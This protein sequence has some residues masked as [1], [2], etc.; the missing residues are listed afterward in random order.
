MAESISTFATFTYL[1]SMF[2]INIAF[3]VHWYSLRSEL[4]GYWKSSGLIVAI[5]FGLQ[6]PTFT[7]PLAEPLTLIMFT[8]VFGCFKL[9][10]TSG[11]GLHYVSLIHGAAVC[12]KSLDANL[13][14]QIS[15]LFILEKK[16]WLAV[17]S[18]SVL[19]LVVF[20]FGLFWV[21]GATTSKALLELGDTEAEVSMLIVICVVFALAFAEEIIFRLG[22]QN[23]LTYS[24]GNSNRAHYSAI[25]FSSF[26]WMLGH[27]GM[28]DPDWAKF[29]QIF[30]IG[31]L[32]G[33]MNRKYGVL[34]C[35]VTH[36]LFN[37][38]VVLIEWTQVFP[39]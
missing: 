38:L 15:E 12:D 3:I 23:W 37:V 28:M 34:A 36:C 7:Q 2:V 17:V 26:I 1:F 4:G 19:F 6:L 35:I 16:G 25:S 33:F 13:R 31:L 22:L 30:L 8:L 10:V 18:A 39:L 5:A 21:T 32:L 24:W 11:V 29:L 20:S 27:V 14:T 9:Y